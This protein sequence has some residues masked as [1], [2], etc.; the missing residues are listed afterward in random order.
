MMTQSNEMM[1]MGSG[2]D[3]FEDLTAEELV[4]ASGG[5]RR[6]SRRGYRG[7]RGQ[8][9]QEEMMQQSE[10]AEP[11]PEAFSNMSTPQTRSGFDG[12][13][14]RVRISSPSGITRT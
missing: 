6:Q 14:V 13:T 12:I 2:F 5:C 7:G 3:D 9:P 11:S 10:M 8:G 1:V 4:L